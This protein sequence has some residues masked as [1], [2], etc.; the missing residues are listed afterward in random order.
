MIKDIAFWSEWE[1][2]CPL[3]EPLDPQ[4]ALKLCDAMYEHARLLGVFPPADPLAGLE[5][6]ISL[7]R[8]VNVQSAPGTD[9]P[10][11]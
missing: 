7:A 11:S 1:S 6:K 5:T 4:R 9:C 8:I 2:R 3:R 10:R